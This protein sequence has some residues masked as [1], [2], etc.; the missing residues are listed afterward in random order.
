[1][2][3]VKAFKKAFE[4]KEE[5][6]WD[7][8]YVFVDIHETILYPTYEL[9]GEKD[10][11]PFAIEVALREMSNEMTFHWDFTHAHIQKKLKFI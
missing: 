8:I 9:N 2:S 3:I 7:K 11:Y 6:G 1:M 4:K 5:R 10:F